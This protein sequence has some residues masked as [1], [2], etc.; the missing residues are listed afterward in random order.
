MS[1]DETTALA[2]AMLRVQADV[3]GLGLGYDEEVD[4]EA[5][6][7]ALEVLETLAKFGFCLTKQEGKDDEKAR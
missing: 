7:V 2:R 6:S 4:Q 3:S 5:I 1:D